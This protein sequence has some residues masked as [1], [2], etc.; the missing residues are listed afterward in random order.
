MR[1]EEREG[2]VRVLALSQPCYNY[3]DFSD[4]NW[5]LNQLIIIW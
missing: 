4:V 3:L 5:Q 2:E 1:E